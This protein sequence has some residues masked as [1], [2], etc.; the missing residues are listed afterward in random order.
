MGIRKGTKLNLTPEERQKRSERMKS[1][2]QDPEF[3]AKAFSPES[4]RKKQEHDARK[5]RF[6]EL[7]RYMMEAPIADEDELLEELEAHGFTQ[8]DYQ[9]A[10]FWSQLKKAI[11]GSD[12]EAA[13][14]V[15]DTAGFKPTEQL[16]VGNL[17]DQ[18]FETIDLSKLSNEQLKEM[19]AKRSFEA[20]DDD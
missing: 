6:N 13:K 12:T 14:F 1:Y 8:A 2:Q 16:Q 10:V 20:Y 7:A 19:V 3:R 5:R 9:S 18:P 17:D 15:R 11:Y 4:I